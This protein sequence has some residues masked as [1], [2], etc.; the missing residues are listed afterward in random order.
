MLS[1]DGA[2]GTNRPQPIATPAQVA[3]DTAQAEATDFAYIDSMLGDVTGGG[4]HGR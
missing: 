3:L 1:E 4:S 2:K